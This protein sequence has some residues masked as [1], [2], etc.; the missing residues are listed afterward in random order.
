MRLF[1][2]A[3]LPDELLGE[4]HD[5]RTSLAAKLAGWRWVRPPGVHLTLRFLGEVAP[6]SDRGARESWRRVAADGRP[7]RVRLGRVGHFPARGR[8]RV[9]WIGVEETNPGGTLASLAAELEQAAR[10]LGFAAESRPFCPHLTLARG[11]RGVRPEEPQDAAVLVGNEVR[12]RDVVLYRS[13]LLAGGARYTALESF[14]LGRPSTNA[15]Q[16]DEAW[17]GQ[18]S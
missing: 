14:P 4:V 2:A 5:V 18:K 1:L 8:P 12:V 17:P 10:G 7:F 3:G 11:R 6:E 15:R 9:L 16:E 13:D